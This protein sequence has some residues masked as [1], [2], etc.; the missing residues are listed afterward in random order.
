M[1]A[2]VLAIVA[3]RMKIT[4]AITTVKV[5]KILVCCDQC[6]SLSCLKISLLRSVMVVSNLDH[7]LEAD[8]PSTY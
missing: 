5:M 3:I 8:L 6:Q 4:G 2:I 7:S 1:K